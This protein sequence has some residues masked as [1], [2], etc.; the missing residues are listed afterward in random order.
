MPS[1]DREKDAAP[2]QFQN[3]WQKLKVLCVAQH[4]GAI[5]FSLS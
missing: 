1:A 3:K 5:N 2:Q 4:F